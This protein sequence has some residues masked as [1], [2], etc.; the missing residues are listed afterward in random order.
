[1]I[2]LYSSY[3]ICRNNSAEAGS[4]GGFFTF[5]GNEIYG[6]SNNHVIANLGQC[7]VDDQ[8]CL[9]GSTQ[10]VGLLKSWT[11]FQQTINYLDIALFK[12]SADMLPVWRMP[13]GVSRPSG[14]GYTLLGD[15]VYFIRNNGMKREGV[16]SELSITRNISFMLNG[17]PFLFTRLIEITPNGDPP[18][19]DPG[20]SGSLVFNSQHAAVGVIIGTDVNK[21]KSYAIPFHNGNTGISS[22]YN[23]QLWLPG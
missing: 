4:L 13:S 20:E 22:V 1:M 12:L 7:K 9:S 2:K 10:Q 3:Q 6:L 11:M 5:G 18:F 19:C 14:I 23:M 8:I 21:S 17:K 16:V 15:E